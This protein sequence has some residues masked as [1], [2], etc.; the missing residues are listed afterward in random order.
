K[1]LN[2]LTSEELKNADA[3]FCVNQPNL[4]KERAWKGQKYIQFTLEPKTY[5]PQCHD[6]NH[7]FDIRATYQESSD[8]PTSYVR[9]D[10]AKWRTVLPFNIT[11]LHK[12][13]TFI[14]FIA[15]HLTEFRKTF[16][17]SIEAHI[18][19]AS[20]GGVNHNTDWNTYPECE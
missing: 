5:C 19:V 12:N 8:I 4:P 11:K 1:K 2:D 18:P 16:I 6:K 17:P 10:S 3:L 13:S 20:F 15:S 7:M 9:M 14:S